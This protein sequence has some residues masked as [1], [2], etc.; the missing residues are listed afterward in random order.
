MRKMLCILAV[1]T[2]LGSLVLPAMAVELSSGSVD[3]PAQDAVLEFF[4]SLFEGL[5]SILQC[6]PMLYL[7]GIFV[8]SFSILIFKLLFHF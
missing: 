8:L 4:P 6:P 1:L 3:V 7:F 2:M 5:T